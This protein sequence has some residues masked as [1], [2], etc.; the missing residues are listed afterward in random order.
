M[1]KGTQ[2][3]NG[4]VPSI[5]V[6]ESVCAW[7]KAPPPTHTPAAIPSVDAEVPLKSSEI[8]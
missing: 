6:W 3:K 5:S 7:H 2:I 1:L 8:L 4:H